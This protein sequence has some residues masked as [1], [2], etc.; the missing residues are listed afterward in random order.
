MLINAILQMGKEGGEESE[1]PWW[2]INRHAE[3]RPPTLAHSAMLSSL[4][5]TPN[6]ACAAS[7]KRPKDTFKKQQGNK[8]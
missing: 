6:P 5:C 1:N 4:S 7:R 3:A 8:V 2:I